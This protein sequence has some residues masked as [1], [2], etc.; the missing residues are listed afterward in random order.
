MGFGCEIGLNDE[1]C[2]RD[3]GM[4]RENCVPEAD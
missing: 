1:Y 4:A 2:L 3:R